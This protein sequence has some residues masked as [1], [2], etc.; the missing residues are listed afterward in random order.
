GDAVRLPRSH[1]QGPRATR[2]SAVLGYALALVVS[3]AGR[4]HVAP[5]KLEIRPIALRYDMLDV[6]IVGEP[7]DASAAVT[8]KKPLLLHQRAPDWLLVEVLVRGSP[9][10]TGQRLVLQQ[11]LG[12][13]CLGD[14]PHIA[15]RSLRRSSTSARTR[16]GSRGPSTPASSACIARAATVS[17]SSI[18]LKRSAMRC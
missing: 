7:S 15:V 8:A 16:S 11:C 3:L 17:P 2:V 13:R 14:V 12:L 18:F 5:F 10:R 4:E 9:V 1:G 6:A